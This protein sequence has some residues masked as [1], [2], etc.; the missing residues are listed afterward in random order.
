M[1]TYLFQRH[2]ETAAVLIL[3]V[4]RNPDCYRKRQ[5]DKSSATTA[6][7]GIADGENAAEPLNSHL[8]KSPGRNS[9]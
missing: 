4:I 7:P 9:T 8:A 1:A 6:M 2:R 3:I 5:I